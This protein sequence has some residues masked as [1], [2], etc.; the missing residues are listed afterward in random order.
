MLKKTI[1][2]KITDV[3]FC[4]RILYNIYALIRV[5]KNFTYVY[6]VE[7]RLNH[8][9]NIGF[10]PLFLKI[11]SMEFRPGYFRKRNCLPFEKK[12][13]SSKSKEH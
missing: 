7:H 4:F 5:M 2:K 6:Y 8:L 12:C 11:L 1:V 13:K 10:E 3:V 9:L